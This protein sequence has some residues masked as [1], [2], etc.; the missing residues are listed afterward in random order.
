MA[1]VPQHPS[2]RALIAIYARY[3]EEVSSAIVRAALA[4]AIAEQRRDAARADAEPKKRPPITD[5]GAGA[6]GRAIIR[7]AKKATI[8]AQRA[9][10]SVFAISAAGAEVATFAYRQSL[11]GLLSAGKT[12]ADLLGVIDINE[13]TLAIPSISLDTMPGGV[14]ALDAWAYKG[15]ERIKPIA[16]R[17]FSGIERVVTDRVRGGHRWE[18]LQKDLQARVGIEKRHA[19]LIARDQ[20]GKLNAQITTEMQTLAGVQR[21]I[22]R[23]VRDQRVRERHAELE[24]TEWDAAGEGAPDA[25][26]YGEP[27]HPGQAIQCRCYREPIV[28]GIPG[29]ER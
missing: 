13:P 15:V 26:P 11:L 24:G 28:E 20:V 29:L 8:K 22:W 3:A 19:E 27:A 5:A 9:A 17:T 16:G 1:F 6:I 23:S 25:G 10:V 4:A 7:A 18:T 2:D 14:E 21:Y 12:A